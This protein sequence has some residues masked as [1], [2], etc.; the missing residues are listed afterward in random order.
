MFTEIFGGSP[1]VKVLDLLIT[2]DD[3]E[4]T[5]KE[6]AECA[7]I[8][9]ST[10][11]TFWDTLERYDIVKKTRRI[12]N[13]WLY[14]INAESPAVKALKEFQL[15]I[16]DLVVEEETKERKHSQL[17]TSELNAEEEPVSA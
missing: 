3:M 9:R 10:L 13:T 5:K 12:G 6:I 14:K 15:R 8:G 17:N 2:Q 4:Y 11:Y 7:E 16:V 1:Q